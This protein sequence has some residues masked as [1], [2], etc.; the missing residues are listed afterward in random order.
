MLI[1]AK[2]ISM[3]YTNSRFDKNGRQALKMRLFLYHRARL[4]GCS[5]KA[6]EEKQLWAVL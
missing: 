3:V 1:E 6:A 5:G 2:D 4:W